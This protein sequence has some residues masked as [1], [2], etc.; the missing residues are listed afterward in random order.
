MLRITTKVS[1]TGPYDLYLRFFP[2]KSHNTD[3]KTD[4]CPLKDNGGTCN[5]IINKVCSHK[6]IIYRDQ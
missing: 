4:H 6:H 2:I 1:K 5:S 3:H